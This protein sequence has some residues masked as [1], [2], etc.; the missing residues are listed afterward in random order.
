MNILVV[1]GGKMGMSHLALLT[2]YIGKSNVALCDSKW[3]TRLFFRFLGYRTFASVDVAEKSLDRLDGVLIA[4]P[5]S[6]H[7]PLARWAIQRK[8]P[9]FVEKPMTL[10][11]ECSSELVTMAKMANVPAQVGFVMRYAA[12]FQHLRQLV[13]EG[14]LGKLKSYTASMKGNVVT[15]VP[16]S[17][18]WLGD[19]TK[20]GGCLNEYGPH[21]IDLCLFIFGGVSTIDAAEKG[22]VYCTNAD[23]CIEVEWIHQNKASGRLEI[24]WC[25]PSKRKSVIEFRVT[26]EYAEV[27]VDNSTLE[28]EWNIDA[29][30]AIEERVQINVLIKPKN[31]GFYLRGEEFSLEIEDFVSICLERSQRVD[32]TIP[33]DSKPS[34]EDGYEVDRLIEEI[35]QKV[36][37]K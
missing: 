21:L 22:N 10:D 17:G 8:I 1:G 33:M 28:I 6:S 20:G 24:D 26:F 9:F 18:S 27:R 13:A 37:L 23:D 3:T 16:A 29:P 36:G 32:S 31:V 30:V 2:Q 7:A 12:P 5:T 4:T 11:V 25:D 19:F 34:L 14:R 15:K 35:A